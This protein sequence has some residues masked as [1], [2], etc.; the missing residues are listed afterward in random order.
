MS[1]L[2]VETQLLNC[3]DL[4]LETEASRAFK[5]PV[6]GSEPTLFCCTNKL[7][8]YFFAEDKLFFYLPVL[9]IKRA[10]YFYRRAD[11][12]SLFQFSECKH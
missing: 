4:L 2:V 3:E 6:M 12:P 9:K 10:V 5:H 7:M 11:D 8:D 1:E